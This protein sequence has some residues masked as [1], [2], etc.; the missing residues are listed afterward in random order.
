MQEMKDKEEINPTEINSKM[1]EASPSLLVN[2][3]NVNG[4]N[5]QMKDKDWQNEFLK[6]IQLYAAYKEFTLDSK[7]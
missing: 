1:T 5:S 4:S 7:T 3:L 2:S 6:I